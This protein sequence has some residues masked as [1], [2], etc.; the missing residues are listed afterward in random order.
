MCGVEMNRYAF[1]IPVYRHG[2]ALDGVLSSL[3]K[4][5]LPFIVVD[6][7]NC[8]SDREHI[9]AAQ[10]KYRSVILVEHKKNRGKGKSVNDGILKAH[11]LGIT[12][13]LQI[14]SDGQHDASQVPFFLEQSRMFPKAVICGYPEYDASVPASRLNGRKIANFWIHVVTFSFEIKDALI[15]F[16]VYPVEPYYSLLKHHAVI[17]SHMGFDIDILVHLHWKNIKVISC[18]VNVSYPKDG[19]SNFRLVRDNLH[20]SLT[21]ARLCAGMIFR[22]PVLIFRAAQRKKNAKALV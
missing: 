14:D 17:D 12:H 9:R 10:K 3:E 22:L 15:G 6:D 18:P 8:G 11:E 2:L 4:Y 19:I 5:N 7:G 21:Y 1:L 13:V 20:I 16:R